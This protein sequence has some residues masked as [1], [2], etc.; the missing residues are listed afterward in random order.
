MILQMEFDNVQLSCLSS[1]SM[2]GVLVCLQSGVLHEYFSEEE[3]I[4]TMT[5]QLHQVY[6][7]LSIRDRSSRTPL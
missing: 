5:L 1:V 2:G 4:R 6:R 7:S 3:Q